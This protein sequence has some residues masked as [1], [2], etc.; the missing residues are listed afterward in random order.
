MSHLPLWYLGAVPEEVCDK[1]KEDFL[2]L[3]SQDA[4]MGNKGEQTDFE[5]RNTTVRFAPEKHWFEP[6]MI[7]TALNGNEVCKW[8]YHVTGRE[9]IQFAEYGP[10][11]HYRWHV[12]TFQLSG[13]P[14][15]RKLTVVCLLNDSSEFEGGELKLRM[16]SEYTA[17]LVKGTVIAFPSIV[18]HCV[19]PILSGTR[20]SATMWLNGPRFR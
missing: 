6:Y 20:Y 13:L 7:Q 14:T 2:S 15:D 8:E 12:D 17:P 19:T 10:E 3:Q 16:Y 9:N 11:Q 4:T 1:A 5:Y 18:E